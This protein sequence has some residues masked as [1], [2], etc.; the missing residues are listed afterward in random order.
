MTIVSTLNKQG[1]RK[2][3]EFWSV[4]VDKMSSDEESAV[5]IWR[6]FEMEPRK[7]IKSHWIHPLMKK[8]AAENLISCFM[9]V[10]R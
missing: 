3:V 4:V 8:R 10:L 2:S 9:I 6:L 7:T 5:A 1:T